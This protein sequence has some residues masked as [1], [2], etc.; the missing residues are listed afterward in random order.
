MTDDEIVVIINEH[1][2]EQTPG[3]NEGQ[4][5]GMLQFMGSQRFRQHF[6]TEQQQEIT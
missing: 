6:M 1:E 5:P 2:S 3:D 4:V